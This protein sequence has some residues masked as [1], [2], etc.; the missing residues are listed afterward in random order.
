MIHDIDDLT[1]LIAAHRARGDARLRNLMLDWR[2]ATNG[3][4]FLRALNIPAPHA[5]RVISE[6]LHAS[7]I[8]ALTLIDAEYPARIKH[9][10]RNGAPPVIYFRGAW[11]L[12]KEPS[13]SIIGTRRPAASGVASARAYAAAL[14]AAGRAVASGNARG[15][16]AAA[17]EGALEAGGATIVF[18]PTPIDSYEP[19]FH[20]HAGGK[21]VLVVSGFVPGLETEL[22]HFQARNQLVAAHAGAAIVAETGARGGTLNTVG[23]ARAYGRPLFVVKVPRDSP[24]AFAHGQLAAGGAEM[25]PPMP[26]A[27]IMRQIVNR[28]DEPMTD[29]LDDTAHDFFPSD[30]AS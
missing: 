5:A 1:R 24:R 26:G 27:A 23:R 12:I 7:G 28:A 14:V 17:H 8:R 29:A 18:P 10:L 22:W 9:F 3:P 25:I 16:D 13:V 11:K 20:V 30:A 21:R 6:I 19:S 4:A 15:I 2:G